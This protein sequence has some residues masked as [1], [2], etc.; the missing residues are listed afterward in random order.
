M[1][2]VCITFI[3]FLQISF[4]FLICQESCWTRDLCISFPSSCFLFP[5]RGGV[6]SL[7]TGGRLKNFRTEGD[8]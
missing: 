8:Y 5:V 7:R 6:K 1:F 4:N 3:A 2:K